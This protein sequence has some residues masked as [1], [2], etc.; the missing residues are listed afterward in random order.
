MIDVV[1]N[2]RKKFINTLATF[3]G[4][5]AS[6]LKR[7]VSYA[8]LP[9]VCWHGIIPEILLTDKALS[10]VSCAI[11]NFKWSRTSPSISCSEPFYY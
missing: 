3:F 1:F 7:I 4:A 6:Y 9:S 10:A 8:R 2:N 11:T 5:D